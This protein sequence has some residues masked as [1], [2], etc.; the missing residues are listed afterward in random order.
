M[1]QAV[2]AGIGNIYSDEILWQAKVNPLRQIKTLNKKELKKIY[3]AIKEV[4]KKA[5]ELRGTSTSDYRDIEGKKGFFQKQRKVYRREGEK[6][7]RCGAI[8][9]K[10]K[11]AGRSARF[12]P[13]CQ[14]V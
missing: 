3:K 12:C 10:I 7:S 14:K 5:V 4:L 2:I 9:K 11:L 8:I 1:N 6:C 13:K